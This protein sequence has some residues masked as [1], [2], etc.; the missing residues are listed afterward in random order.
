MARAADQRENVAGGRVDRHQSG[1]EPGPVKP[2]EPECDRPLGSVLSCRQEGRLDVPVGWMVAAELVP[3]LLPQ[4][5][6]RPGR[7]LLGLTKR[8]DAGLHAPDLCES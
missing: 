7:A 2:I 3:E 6:L 1:F 8:L 4:E 5:V